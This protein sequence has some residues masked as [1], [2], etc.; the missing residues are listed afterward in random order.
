MGVLN[1]CFFRITDICIYFYIFR[2]SQGLEP[3]DENTR[4]SWVRAP[5][6]EQKHPRSNFSSKGS[7][8]KKIQGVFGHLLLNRMWFT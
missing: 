8:Q 3:T 5:C 1:D 4:F 2:S 6:I 7:R